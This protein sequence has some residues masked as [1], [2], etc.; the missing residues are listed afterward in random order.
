MRAWQPNIGRPEEQPDRLPCLAAD[1]IKLPGGATSG[2]P[3]CGRPPPANLLAQVFD[4]DRLP[5]P[6]AFLHL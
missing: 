2:P 6:G 1:L 3:P 5:A 4:R